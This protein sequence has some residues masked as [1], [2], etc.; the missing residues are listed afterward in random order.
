VHVLAAGVPPRVLH[1]AIGGSG[2][3]NLRCVTPVGIPS[4]LRCGPLLP[5]LLFDPMLEVVGHYRRGKL[6]LLALLLCS[7]S[8]LLHCFI[9]SGVALWVVDVLILVDLFN[10]G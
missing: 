3:P 7:A 5:G 8:V 1:A 2:M 6:C 4:M 9:S 10:V